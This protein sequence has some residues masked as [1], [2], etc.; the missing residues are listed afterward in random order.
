MNHFRDQKIFI[1]HYIA[2][3]LLIIV[4]MTN[5]QICSVGQTKQ[6]SVARN[7]ILLH[8]GGQHTLRKYLLDNN[9]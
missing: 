8:L 7:R 5:L 9:P 4:N 1:Q 2:T 6:L 3:F